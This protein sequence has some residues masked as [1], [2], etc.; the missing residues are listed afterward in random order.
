MSKKVT[1]SIIVC[2]YKTSDRFYTDLARYKN[3]TYKNFEIILVAEKDEKL[4]TEKLNTLS[5]PIKIIKAEKPKISLGEKRDIGF[6][7]AIGEF[8]AYTD[9]DAYPDKDWLTNT[10]RVFHKYSGVGAV[11]G[12]NITPKNDSFWAKIGGYIY[13]SYLTS[14]GAQ[15]RFVPKK[16][17]EVREIQGVNMIIPKKILEELGGFRF[18]LNSGDDDKICMDLRKKGYKIIYDPEVTVYHHRREFP[19]GHLKQVKEMGTHRGFFL[20]AFPKTFGPIYFYPP[21]MVISS[22]ILIIISFFFVELRFVLLV[23]FSIYFFLCY[24]SATKRT[25]II[26]SLI[27]AVGIMLTHFTYGTFF[28][29]G[30]MIRKIP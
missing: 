13:E 11:G 6:K 26:S 2:L 19:I 17:G 29:K 10:L 30:L 8:C 21:T 1:F 9:D 7:S 20:K 23:L 5:L 25:G 16:K 14:A 4:N 27:V 22:L 12:P 24:I 3:L 28:L 15:Y 18:S